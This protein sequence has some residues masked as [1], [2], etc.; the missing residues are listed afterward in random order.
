MR[1]F[2]PFRNGKT[3]MFYL[4]AEADGV[5]CEWETY[6]QMCFEAG[7]PVVESDQDYE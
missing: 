3:P 6:E 2:E 4:G 5:C 1:A 7:L